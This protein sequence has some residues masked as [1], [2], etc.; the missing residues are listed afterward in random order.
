MFKLDLKHFEG[1]LTLKHLQA[2]TI[3]EYLYYGLKFQSIGAFNNETISRFL[4]EKSNM[5]NV[6]RSFIL[7]LKKYLIHSREELQLTEE[8]FRNIVQTEVPSITGR[9]K[10][11]L[12]IP[13]TKSEMETIE[14]LLDTEE[15][16]LMFLTCYHGGLRLQELMKIKISSF[17]WE[18]LKESPG[19]MGE[20][21]VFGK[22]GKEGIALLPN[23]LIK[24]IA[25]YIKSKLFKNGTESYLFNMTGRNFE[26]KLREVGIKSGITK[27]DENG[28]YIENTIVHPHRL[29]HQLG[30][31]LIKSGVDI[32]FIK[33]IL[34]HSNINSTQI[35][36][37]LS[38]QDLKDKI[39]EAGIQE[40]IN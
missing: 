21:R 12:N 32:R 10:V 30:Y 5:N 25:I 4:L 23:W 31:D 15:L 18:S 37:Q 3:K 26:K 27:K 17:N 36:T 34:R 7:I 8:E 28:Q 13:L 29:R 19:E 22:G 9:T 14:S 35:Y 20:V 16:K 2:R 1:Y 24:R 38:K 40:R 39:Q 6:A 11:K 33:D